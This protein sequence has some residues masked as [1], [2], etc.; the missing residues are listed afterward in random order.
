MIKFFRDIRQNLIMENKTGK[1]AAMPSAGKPAG[2][3]LK[4][5]IGEIVL[6]VIGILIA[7]QINNWNQDRETIKLAKENYLNLLASLEQDSIK[8]QQT[9]KLN[10][11]GLNA[12]IKIIPLERNGELL[13][14]PQENLNDFLYDVSLT[15]RSFLPNSGIYNIL[16]SNNG[17][18]LIKSDNLKALLIHLYDYLYTNYEIVDVSIEEKYV[19][20]LSS[21]IKEKVG[22]VWQFTPE[23][24]V[25]QPA[26]PE[27]FKEHYFELAYEARDLYSLV[28]YNIN[29]LNQ[30]EESISEL[31]PL[32]RDEIKK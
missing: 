12:L 21:I 7:L 9:I 1:P 17:L 28:S 30:I 19:N 5:A 24:S 22:L 14:L 8:V 6:V 2:R 11:K 13:E 26:S 20:Q 25:I 3:Y 4:Y 15:S 29:T 32:I 16:T 10:E 27:R 18:E 23:F 31:L